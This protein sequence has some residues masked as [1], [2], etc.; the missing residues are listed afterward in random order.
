M[1]FPSEGVSKTEPITYN[2]M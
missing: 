1:L 2:M